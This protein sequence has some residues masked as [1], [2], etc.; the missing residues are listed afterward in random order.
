M[1]EKLN[2]IYQIWGR[3]A[4][5]GEIGKERTLLFFKLFFIV[6]WSQ[7]N[8]S[9]REIGLHCLCLCGST[10]P[11]EGGGYMA[12]RYLHQ[13]ETKVGMT[14]SFQCVIL[15]FLFFFLFRPFTS[16]SPPIFHFKLLISTSVTLLF[17]QVSRIAYQNCNFTRCPAVFF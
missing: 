4:K 9:L 11:F 7:I 10:C 17:R 12:G 1:N 3:W 5:L 15:D 2:Y 6:K 16:H 14:D 8:R 13:S